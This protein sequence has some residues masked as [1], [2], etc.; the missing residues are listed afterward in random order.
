MKAMALVMAVLIGL[1]AKGKYPGI[2]AL[3]TLYY[4]AASDKTA[5]EQFMQMLYTPEAGN[6]PIMQCYRSMAWFLRAKHAVNPFYK[7]TYFNKGKEMLETSLKQDPCNAEIRFLR[8][9]IETNVP[10]FLN[11]NAYEEEDKKVLL[12]EWRHI[13]DT[14]LKERVKDYLKGYCSETEKKIFYE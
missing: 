9:C 4:Q 7:W 8:F 6:D 1:P 14:D 11:Y 3:R 13:D 2:K 10:F 12:R 5:T